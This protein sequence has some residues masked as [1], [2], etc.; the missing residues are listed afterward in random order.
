MEHAK[1]KPCLREQKSCPTYCAMWNITIGNVIFILKV[2]T[3]INCKQRNVYAI[4]CIICIWCNWDV[5]EKQRANYTTEKHYMLGCTFTQRLWSIVQGWS[6]KH[7]F[8]IHNFEENVLSG[9]NW[10]W[11]QWVRM[12]H[13]N[14]ELRPFDCIYNVTDLCFQLIWLTNRYSIFWWRLTYNIIE[15]QHCI[16]SW[17]R[18]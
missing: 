13:E 2:P 11:T 18:Q 4:H 6:L 3:D 8:I 1:Y 17:L 10:T 12:D 7:N 15:D 9:S 5:L 14:I 16:F